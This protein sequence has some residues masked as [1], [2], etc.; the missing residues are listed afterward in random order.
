MSAEPVEGS[1]PDH[2]SV[3]AALQAAE[4]REGVARGRWR[5][6]SFDWPHL[7]VAIR[8]ARRPDSVTE[9]ALRMDLTGYPQ[10]APTSTPWDL[11]TNSQLA[12][13]RRPRGEFASHVFRFDWENGRALYAPY[14]RAALPGH[15][16][17]STQHP[18]D[19]WTPQRTLSFILDRVHRLLN[20]DDYEGCA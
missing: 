20:D 19:V 14:D 5:V 10:Q 11:E 1:T 18:A 16:S 3:L 6:V 2:R 7:V 13:H 4:F 17:W 12:A 15:P 9:V 8:A